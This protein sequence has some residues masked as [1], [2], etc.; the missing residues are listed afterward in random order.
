MRG[1][2]VLRDRERL[3]DVAGR[4]P[5]R[6]VPGEQSKYVQPGRLSQRCEGENGVFV[7]PYIQIYR[8]IAFC[9]STAEWLCGSGPE[10]T[11]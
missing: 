4:E 3:G 6:L 9:Q 11:I 8:Y 1:H 2:G 10:R 5:L 7:I